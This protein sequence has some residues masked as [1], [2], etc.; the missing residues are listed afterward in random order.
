MSDEAILNR[1]KDLAGS[2]ELVQ[3]NGRLPKLRIKS[4]TGAAEIYL[5]GAQVTSWKPEGAEEVLFVSEKSHWEAGRAIR[6][7]IPVCFPW[8]RAKADDPQAPTHGFVRTKMWRLESLSDEDEGSVTA[9]FTMESD[10]STRRWWPYD[11]RLEYRIAVGAELKLELTVRNT[12]QAELQL[13]EA[14]HTYFNVGDVERAEVKGLDGVAYLDN[15]DGNRRKVQLGDL[16]PTGQMDNAYLDAT[17]EVEI[18]DPARGRWL[19]TRKANSHSTIVWN[20]WREGAASLSDFGDEEWRQM[21][22]VEGGNIIGSAIILKPDETHTL[23]V[24][25]SVGELTGP[26]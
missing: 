5:Y 2:V 12:G 23:R 21:L 14:L 17:G 18:A 13:E 25:I 20:P 11:F 16:R 15:R 19:K 26:E 1:L 3:G 6:G 22:C 8:F 7:G 24:V 9:L 10:D 4:K